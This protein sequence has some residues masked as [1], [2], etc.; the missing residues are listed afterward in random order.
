MNGVEKKIT[1]NASQEK[2]FKVISDVEGYPG[3]LSDMEE[4]T[5][6][7]KS[8]K[9]IVASFTLQLITKIKYTLKIRLDKPNSISWTLVDGQMMKANTGSWKLKKI[10]ANK[11]E[12]T[13][14][15]DIKLGALVPKS[16]VNTLVESNLP[17]MLKSFKKRIEKG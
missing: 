17:R 3:F 14:S 15:I 6:E 4:V 7:K 2:A 12:A 16:I 5:V 8:T 13:Y 1:I 11:T 10:S 9:E